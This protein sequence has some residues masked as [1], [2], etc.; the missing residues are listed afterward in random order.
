MEAIINSEEL[1]IFDP[2]TAV[3]EMVNYKWK[4]YA[5]ASH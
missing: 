5:F 4:A 1:S 3:R 2:E